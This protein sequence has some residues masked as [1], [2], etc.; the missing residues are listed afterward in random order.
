MSV[1]RCLVLNAN[2]EFLAVVDRWIDALA[3]VVV[4]KAD[5][6]AC[7]DR[8]VRSERSVHALPAVPGCNIE[9]S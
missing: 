3:L 5:P 7:Y 2:Y 4:G 8:V 9:W 6:L 1:N